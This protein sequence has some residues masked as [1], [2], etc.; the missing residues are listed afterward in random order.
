MI[1]YAA[2]NATTAAA[3]N[4]GIIHD[5]TFWVALAFI[6]FFIL[7]GK[8]LYLMAGS[9]LDDRSDAIRARLDEA[10]K[11]REEAQELLAANKRKQHEAEAEAKLFLERAKE[12]AERVRERL[13]AEMERSLK[14]RQQLAEDRIAQAEASAIDEVRDM[15]TEIALKASEKILQDTMTATKANKLIDEAIKELPGKFH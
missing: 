10:D 12:E 3:E 11:L 8:K 4:Q 13:T 9:A 6:V 1:A 14:R 2:D 15:A 7:V 5:P